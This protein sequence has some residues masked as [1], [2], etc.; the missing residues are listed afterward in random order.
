MG[1][2]FWSL[3]F[4][5]C[6]WIYLHR[7]SFG[8]ACYLGYPSAFTNSKFF[9]FVVFFGF[10]PIANDLVLFIFLTNDSKFRTQIVGIF[11]GCWSSWPPMA[12]NRAFAKSLM[13]TS[14]NPACI[15]LYLVVST[16]FGAVFFKEL[17]YIRFEFSAIITL[18]HLGIPEHYFINAL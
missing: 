8:N 17:F 2:C 12:W 14:I 11:L 16:N 1:L 6:S 10:M 4:L 3:C 13:H 5:P 18:K 15:C 7:P 9:S